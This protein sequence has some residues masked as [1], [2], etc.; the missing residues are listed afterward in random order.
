VSKRIEDEKHAKLTDFRV[1]EN[2]MVWFSEGM[3]N[4]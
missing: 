3:S 4:K 1:K 2:E